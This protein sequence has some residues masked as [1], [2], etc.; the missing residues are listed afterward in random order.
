[1][2]GSTKVTTA[3]GKKYLGSG[4]DVIQVEICMKLN[5]SLFKQ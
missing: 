1:M 3:W 2:R 5:V 4:K